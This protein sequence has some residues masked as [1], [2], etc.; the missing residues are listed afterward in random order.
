MNSD[1]TIMPASSRFTTRLPRVRLPTRYTSATDSRLA[2]KA[3]T[4]TVTL[5]CPVRMASAAPKHAPEDAPKI[6]GAAI[7][8]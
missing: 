2:Q 6:S 1:P 8:F 4:V 3:Y 5:L 7:G